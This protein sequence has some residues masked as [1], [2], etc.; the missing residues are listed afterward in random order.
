[1]TGL[2]SVGSCSVRSCPV[3]N[4]PGTVFNHYVIDV[5]RENH[6][7]QLCDWEV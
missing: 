1:M 3:G 7:K 6:C 5:E 2:L 4:C